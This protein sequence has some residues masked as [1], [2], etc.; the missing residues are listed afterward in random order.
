MKTVFETRDILLALSFY[1]ENGGHTEE[2]LKDLQKTFDDIA[3]DEIL[4]VR[5]DK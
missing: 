1:M 2:R 5:K 3:N 4:I